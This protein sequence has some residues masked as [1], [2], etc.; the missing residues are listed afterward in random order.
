MWGPCPLPGS[1][2]RATVGKGP[3]T[4]SPSKPAAL[5][6][7]GVGSLWLGAGELLRGRRR[8][9]GRGCRR[10]EVAR[11]GPGRAQ[12][13]AGLKA[14]GRAREALAKRR[15]R[16]GRCPSLAGARKARVGR[17]GD[18]GVE[19]G[20]S[21]LPGGKRR[22]GLPAPRPRQG[23]WGAAPTRRVRSSAARGA[24]GPGSG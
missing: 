2:I 22:P 23:L 24:H 19:S 5:A 12:Q 8:A 3:K 15:F 20:V 4:C 21:G 17:A 18:S 10:E 13:R 16:R 7:L 6:A 1:R 14:L 11:T 9:R